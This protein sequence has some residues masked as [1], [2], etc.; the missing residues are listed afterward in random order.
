[1]FEQMQRH[2]PA[3]AVVLSVHLRIGP[4]QGIEPDSLRFGWEAICTE[5]KIPVPQLQLDMLKWQLKCPQCG[6][7]WEDDQIYVACTCGCATPTVD[8]GAGTG[9]GTGAELQMVSMEVEEG[10]S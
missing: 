7:Q 2:T 1:M 6:R 3:G 10:K 8:G 4:M 9:A 5:A